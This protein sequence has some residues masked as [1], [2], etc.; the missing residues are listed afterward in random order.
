MEKREFTSWAIIFALVAAA[1]CVQI[2]LLYIEKKKKGDSMSQCESVY[3]RIAKAGKKGITGYELV[4]SCYCPKYT[5]RISEINK[6]FNHP[7]EC[8]PPKTKEEHWIYKIKSGYPKKYD[9][10][11]NCAYPCK[12]HVTRL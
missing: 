11:Y 7:I 9:D 1:I 10:L 6:K 8:I 12:C 5:N 2:L 4:I 3:K